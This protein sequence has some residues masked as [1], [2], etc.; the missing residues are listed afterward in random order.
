MNK[1]LKKGKSKF[2]LD[3]NLA[4]FSRLYNLQPHRSEVDAFILCC[5]AEAMI[6]NKKSGSRQGESKV[7]IT[8]PTVN[9]K[10]E[11]VENDLYESADAL[12]NY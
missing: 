1:K 7:V 6:K 2:Y 5:E 11:K 12:K 3:D 4:S 10:D 9:T 8:R